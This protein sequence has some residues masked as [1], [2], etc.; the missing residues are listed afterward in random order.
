MTTTTTT[1]TTIT[2]TTNSP[3]PMS[4]TRTTLARVWWAVLAMIV[5]VSVPL[6]LFDFVQRSGDL[7]MGTAA[8][9]HLS[10]FTIQS[11][12]LVLVSV[13]PLSID[14]RHDGTLW[15]VL[16]LSSL[17]GISITALVFAVVFANVYK[18]VG[19]ASW[20]NLA[21][22]NIVPALALV[23]W[24]AFGPWGRIEGSIA[25]TWVWPLVWIAWT[26]LHGQASD[27]Y[28]YPFV[29][30]G[31]VGAAGVVGALA[32]SAVI[33]VVFLLVFRFVD[34]KLSAR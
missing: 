25:R 33:A 30:P 5:A 32:V 8:L 4:P 13:V 7:N 31:T 18:P 29:D 16:R 28:P 14:P 22:H 15:R 27:W 6:D 19:I 11:N 2:T 12:L 21:L 17:L 9:R 10:F 34:R 26:L 1:T 3:T 20:T 23:G 24:V